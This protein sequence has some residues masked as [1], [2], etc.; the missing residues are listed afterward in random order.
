MSFSIYT[1]IDM[2]RVSIMAVVLMLRL[3]D[4]KG[5]RYSINIPWKFGVGDTDNIFFAFEHVVLP[6]AK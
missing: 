3:V 6:I 2:E 5:E 4:P 1:Y